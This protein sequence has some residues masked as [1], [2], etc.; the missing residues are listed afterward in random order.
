MIPEGWTAT[1][2]VFKIVN[3]KDHGTCIVCKKETKWDETRGKY[4]RLCDDP[5][6]KHALREAALKNHIKVYGKPTLLND[7]AHQQKMLENRKISGKYNFRDGGQIGYVGSFERKLLE[8]FDK[9][10]ECRSKDIIEPGPTLEYS[11]HGRKCKWITDFLYVPYNL[12]IE[13]KD[14]GDNPNKREMESYRE[15]QLQKEKMITNLGTYN[16][17]R[18][19]NNNFIQLLEL[20]AEM[21]YALIDDTQDNNKIFIRINEGASTMSRR[22]IEESKNYKFEPNP[23]Y[24]YEDKNYKKHPLY[25]KYKKEIDAYIYCGRRR[26]SK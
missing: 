25:N 23:K 5:R 18:V 14:G 2:V 16:Y 17:I 7:A 1:R 3:G 20:F 21:K 13:V 9:V 10:L 11:Y 4:E 24:P 22:V 6:C 26:K 12:V 19:T 8:F 15:K